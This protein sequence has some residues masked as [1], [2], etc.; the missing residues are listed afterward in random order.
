MKPLTMLQIIYHLDKPRPPSRL[1]KTPLLNP[2]AQV[3][4]RR[5]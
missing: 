3:P 2:I 1:D 4:P 5:A